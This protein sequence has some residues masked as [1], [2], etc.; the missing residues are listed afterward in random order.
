MK[1]Q[2]NF[3]VSSKIYWIKKRQSELARCL[4]K[5]SE[6]GGEDKECSDI[7]INDCGVQ[8]LLCFGVSQTQ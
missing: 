6:E 8:V 4:L 5:V 7:S 1:H 3:R 2:R